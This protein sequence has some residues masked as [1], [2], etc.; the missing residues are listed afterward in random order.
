MN[1]SN[2]AMRLEEFAA[3]VSVIDQ[4]EPEQ[5]PPRIVTAVSRIERPAPR[6]LS[7]TARRIQNNDHGLRPFR[8]L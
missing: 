5:D 6:R 4:P 8:I 1:Y 3:I 7:L 2:L